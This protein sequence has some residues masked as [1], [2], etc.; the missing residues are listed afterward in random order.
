MEEGDTVEEGHVL[1]RLDA[2]EQ[3][4]ALGQAEAALAEA[5]A[6]LARLEAAQAKKRQD[7]D[8][9]R[10]VDTGDT[11]IRVRDAREQLKHLS[12]ASRAEG[13]V[14]TPEGA[15]LEAER[16]AELAEAREELK[17]AQEALLD[18]MGRGETSALPKTPESAANLAAR[19][20]ALV[21]ARIKLLDAR[22]ALGDAEDLTEV[23]EDGQDRVDTARKNLANATRD[24]VVATLARRDKVDEA[25]DRFDDEEGQHRHVHK[26][27]L[28]VVM[29]DEEIGEDPDTLFEAWGVDLESVFDARNLVYSGGVAP[30]VP[31]TRWNE[32][33]IY[34]WL[35]LHPNFG[36][37]SVTCEDTDVLTST[38]DLY[39]KGDQGRVG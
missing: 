20:K 5:Q 32:L 13:T 15:A 18:A 6:G 36:S 3:S 12:G 24:L 26:K 22:D 38:G 31:S 35:R 28:G 2:D 11:R 9:A 34:A 19:Q 1:L 37:I 30:D 7:E 25:Q 33:T 21:D 23:L 17:D 4:A 14:L 10:P 39:R 29:T 8:E 16:A 27:W